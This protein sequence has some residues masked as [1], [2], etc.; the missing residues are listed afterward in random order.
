MI[1]LRWVGWEGGI[2]FGRLEPFVDDCL[3]EVTSDADAIDGSPM[4]TFGNEQTGMR[5]RTFSGGHLVD[6]CSDVAR[7]TRP[8]SH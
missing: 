4:K 3:L 5:C 8:W 7:C 2:R 6:V 1:C